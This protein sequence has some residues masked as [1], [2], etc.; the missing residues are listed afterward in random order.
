MILSKQKI[1]SYGKNTY[2]YYK[3]KCKKLISLT[4]ST[5]STATPLVSF[6]LIFNH[7]L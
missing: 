1:N 3:C 2:V 7:A 5:V 4:I 6:S